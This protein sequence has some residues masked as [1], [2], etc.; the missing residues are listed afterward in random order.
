M[1]NKTKKDKAS[2][3][4]DIRNIKATLSSMGKILQLH[5]QLIEALAKEAGLLATKDHEVTTTRA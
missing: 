3:I 1:K 2:E 5:Q 4:E